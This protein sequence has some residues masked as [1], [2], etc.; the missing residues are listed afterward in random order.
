MFISF[1]RQLLY[2]THELIKKMMRLKKL[3]KKLSLRISINKKKYFM[4]KENVRI[5]KNVL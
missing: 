1:L 2:I 5:M 4:V 3:L